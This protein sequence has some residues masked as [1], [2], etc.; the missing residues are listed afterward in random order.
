[1]HRASKREL[2]IARNPPPSR[3]HSCSLLCHRKVEV[4]R[5]RT[6]AKD[7]SVP[8][9]GSTLDGICSSTVRCNKPL[10]CVRMVTTMGPMLSANTRVI[11]FSTRG[12][13]ITLGTC[14][15]S[16]YSSWDVTARNRRSGNR[17]VQYRGKLWLPD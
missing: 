2:K 14:A 4:K 7:E 8:G 15:S 11:K 9:V 10:R 12:W 13:R 17:P 5:P 6:I 1:M 3:A 16:F